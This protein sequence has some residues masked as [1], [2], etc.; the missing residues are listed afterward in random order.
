MAATTTG[1][2]KGATSATIGSLSPRNVRSINTESLTPFTVI[3][4]AKIPDLS[5]TRIDD[6]EERQ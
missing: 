1:M 2:D 5:E 3:P 4:G 6:R